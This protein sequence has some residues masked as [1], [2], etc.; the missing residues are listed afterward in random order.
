MHEGAPSLGESNETGPVAWV[1]DQEGLDYLVEAII[2]ASEVVVDLETTGLQEY[3]VEGGH[4]NGGVGARISLAAYT[5]PQADADGRWNGE[6]PT[7]Y[8]LPL[9]HPDSPWR[10]SW[11]RTLAR[12]MI[13]AVE[14]KIPI[15]NQNIKFDS[16][17]I[18]AQ[19]GV[20]ISHLIEWDTKDGSHLLDNTQ[21]TK[22]K[23]GVPREFPGVERWDD[24]DLSKPGASEQVPLLDLGAYAARDTWW[25]WRWCEKQRQEMFLGV[26]DEPYGTDEVVNARLGKLAVWVQMPTVK[27][28]TRLE[29]RGFMLDVPW[30]EETLAGDREIK[31]TALDQMAEMYGMDRKS[32]STAPT[33]HWFRD[34]ATRAVENGDLIV[35]AMTPSGQPQW[36]RGV[37]TRQARQGS[38]AAALVLKQRKSTKRA[39]YLSGWLQQVTPAGLIHARYNTGS[40]ATGRLSSSEPNMQQV[41]KALRPAFIPRPGYVIADFDYSQIE[42]RVAAFISRCEPM[43]QAFREG[44]DL[45]R[46]LAQ[47]VIKVRENRV[48]TLDEVDAEERQGAKAGNF[49][50]LFGMGVYGFRE[51]AETAYGVIMTLEEASA[52]HRAFFDTWAGMREWHARQM[53]LVHRDGYIASPLGRIRRLPGIWDGNDKVVSFNERAA[54]NTPVQGMASDLMQLSLASIQGMLPGDIGM[55]AIEGV[56][57][58]ATVHDSIVLELPEDRWESLAYRVAERM[59]TLDKVLAKMG[60]TFDVP[61][62]AD[63]SVGTRWSLSDVSSPDQPPAVPELDEYEPE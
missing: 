55:D 59:Q 9:S 3:A 40:V 46:M 21:S 53:A 5:I 17:W 61:L 30:V 62:V 37:L 12:T 35:T 28:L 42:L 18:Y 39:E 10:G 45:H 27:S 11:R 8:V 32:A 4:Q 63:Y 36:T 25:T 13:P 33:S 6:V 15:V 31:V 52:I 19:T 48:V 41:T 43:I 34:W 16:R 50:L 26:D 29:Q 7:T 51:Y 54:I 56:H 47:Q 49:G 14:H 60:I 23:E 38:E 22:L 44:K 1:L 57:P 58:V 24:F 2:G 20:D